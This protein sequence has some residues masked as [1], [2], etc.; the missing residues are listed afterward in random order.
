LEQAG[1]RACLKLGGLASILA[2]LLPI[3]GVLLLLLGKL[4]ESRH[5]AAAGEPPPLTVV[6]RRFVER[7]I[8]RGVGW[9]LGGLPNQCPPTLVSARRPVA[10]IAQALPRP[11]LSVRLILHPKGYHL[12]LGCC[13]V[14]LQL[15]KLMVF[16]G[17]SGNFIRADRSPAVGDIS[18]LLSSRPVASEYYCKNT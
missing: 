15:A 12:L 1:F 14:D 6:V 10:E 9:G 13:S 16:T 7:N 4:Q 11:L 8:S 3:G 5:S 2:A 18:F 17:G